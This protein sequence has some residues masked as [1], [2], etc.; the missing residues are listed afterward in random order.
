MHELET[1]VVNLDCGSS[2]WSFLTFPNFSG[3]AATGSG[4]SGLQQ[5]HMRGV[6]QRWAWRPRQECVVHFLPASKVLP[7]PRR[8]L[9]LNKGVGGLRC[10]GDSLVSL[11]A[12]QP[13]VLLQ[14]RTLLI[15]K[16]SVNGALEISDRASR[17]VLLGG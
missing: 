14:I 13:S 15:K 7:E 10:G 16:L 5:S 11:A 9:R 17:L 6:V 3:N 1:L 2:P 12:A 4:I 8:F